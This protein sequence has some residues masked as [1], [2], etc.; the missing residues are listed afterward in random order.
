MSLSTGAD[1]DSDPAW[2]SCVRVVVW[3]MGWQSGR[4]A[5]GTKFSPGPCLKLLVT[6][7]G[8][9]VEQ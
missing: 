8:K 5:G 7:S 6:D 1:L 4:E 3:D 2:P 9:P